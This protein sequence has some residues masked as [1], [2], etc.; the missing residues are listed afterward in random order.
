[1]SDTNEIS[2]Y[3]PAGKP[4]QERGPNT[5]FFGSRFGRANT[6]DREEKVG[7]LYEKTLVVQVGRRFG[8]Y[9]DSV[10]LHED[11]SECLR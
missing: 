7:T 10:T 3:I 1:M 5:S 6:T 8:E 4:H 11:V 2:S 9:T